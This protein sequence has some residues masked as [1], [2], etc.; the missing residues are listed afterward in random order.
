MTAGA[1]VTITENANDI[2]IAAGTTG[3]STLAD[4]DYG[5]ITVSSTGTVMTIDPQ[6][7]TFGKIQNLTAPGALLG[8][9]SAGA[10][11]AQEVVI[12]TGL[13]LSSNNLNVTLAP[14]TTS[15]LAEGSNLYFTEARVRATPLTSYTLGSNVAITASDTL[16]AALGKIQAQINNKENTVAPGTT[17]QYYR[18]LS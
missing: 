16:L 15:N 3:G 12:G 17:S 9:H 14:F 7:V 6:A 8:R 18:G 11:S 2:T 13:V 1:N 5:D 4:G 10:G